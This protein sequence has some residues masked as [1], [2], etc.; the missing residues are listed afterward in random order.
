MSDGDT[1]EKQKKT[2]YRDLTQGWVKYMKHLS[3]RMT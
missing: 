2:D 3:S 1:D